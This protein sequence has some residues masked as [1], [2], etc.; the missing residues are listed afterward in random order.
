M[1]NK[2]V[3]YAP[4]G[5]Q[6]RKGMMKNS[7]DSLCTNFNVVKLKGEKKKDVVH[8]IRLKLIINSFNENHPVGAKFLWKPSVRGEA[9][10]VTVKKPAYEFY[11]M[12]VAF[13]EERSGFC[14]I[15]PQFIG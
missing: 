9:I 12:A 10:T 15:E 6:W 8:K 11:G 1:Q 7:I 3:E 4:F 14:S 5:D 2:T 13:F